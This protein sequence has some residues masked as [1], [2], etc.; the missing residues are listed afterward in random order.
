MKC[1]LIKCDVC[2]A[3]KGEGNKWLRAWTFSQGPGIYIAPTAFTQV[4]MN[5][6]RGSI[7]EVIDLCSDTCLQK[8]IGEQLKA[9][10]ELE[11]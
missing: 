6:V 9:I 1:E 11:T 7:Y 3:V 10:R 2:G 4:A 5:F 8:V